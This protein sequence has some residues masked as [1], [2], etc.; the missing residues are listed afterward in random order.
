VGTAAQRW[1]VAGHCG[2]Q[3]YRYSTSNLLMIFSS[4][5]GLNNPS[6]GVGLTL[7]YLGN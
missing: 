3:R 6:L 1:S 2:E 4:A 7:L 5:T